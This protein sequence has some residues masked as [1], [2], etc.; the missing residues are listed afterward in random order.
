MS[1]VNGSDAKPSSSSFMGSCGAWRRFDLCWVLGACLVF[2]VRVCYCVL[3]CA[4][5]SVLS[6]RLMVLRL[7]NE[8]EP[9]PCSYVQDGSFVV[10]SNVDVVLQGSFN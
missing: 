5:V 10:E 9:L 1:V 8:T 4:F 7:R 6:A 2:I 3:S